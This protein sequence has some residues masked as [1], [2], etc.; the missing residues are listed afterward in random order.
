VIATGAGSG[1]R[2]AVGNVVLG[3]MSSA[4]IFGIFLVP[5]LYVMIQGLVERTMS[6]K[7]E[8]DPDSVEI[9]AAGAEP[10][11]PST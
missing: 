10:E 9:D 6:K 2:R 5:V 1:S 11:A 7:E 4:V 3:G 8:D